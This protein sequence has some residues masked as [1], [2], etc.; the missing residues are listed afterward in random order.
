MAIL[1]NINVRRNFVNFVVRLCKIPSYFI[2][3][4]EAVSGRLVLLY[5]GKPFYASFDESVLQGILF[6]E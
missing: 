3:T 6:S 4:G 1:Q 2:P 5:C